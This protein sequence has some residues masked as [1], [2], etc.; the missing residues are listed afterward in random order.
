MMIACTGR[1]ASL[2]S[3]GLVVVSVDVENHPIIWIRV[4]KGMLMALLLLWMG[5]CRRGWRCVSGCPKGGTCGGKG[6]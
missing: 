4:N 6:R 1:I 2:R 5:W 3:S